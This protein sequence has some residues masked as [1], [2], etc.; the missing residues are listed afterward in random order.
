M[1]TQINTASPASS[2]ISV[3][4]D[5]E[6][7]NSIAD[8]E[9]VLGGVN[10]DTLDGRPALDVIARPRQRT[11]S[12]IGLT[13]TQWVA[14]RPYLNANA[15]LYWRF[16]H[17][18]ADTTWLRRSPYKATPRRM[19]GDSNTAPHWDITDIQLDEVL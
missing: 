10:S 9:R 17:E 15:T 12:F 2:G 13:N 5:P 6:Y 4:K 11:F 16:P 19:G 3:G 18:S 7:K 8:S 14:L 1:T